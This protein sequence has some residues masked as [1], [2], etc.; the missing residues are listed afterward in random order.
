[1]R[2]PRLLLLIQS[3]MFQVSARPSVVTCPAGT[4]SKMGGAD[5][6]SS[7]NRVAYHG[8]R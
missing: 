8:S 1:M 7:S 5:F 2:P 6:C 4:R 3:S